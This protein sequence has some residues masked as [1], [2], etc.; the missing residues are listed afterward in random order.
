MLL[1]GGHGPRGLRHGRH[2][3]RARGPGPRGRAGHQRVRPR[4]AGDRDPLCAMRSVPPTTS[5]SSATPCGASPRSSTASSARSRAKPF[6]DG[7]GSGAHI[8]FSL[9]SPDGSRNLMHDPDAGDR[10]LSDLGRSFVAGV[11]QH[12][13][14]LVALTCP[15][16]NSYERL[17]PSA[18]A[19][20]TVSWGLDNREGSVRVASP[21]RGREMESTNVE[22]KACDPS[23]NP[24]LA[25]GG[26]IHAGLDGVRRGLEPPEPARNDPARMTEAERD[27]ERHPAAAGLAA[28]GARGPPGRRGAVRDARRHA[29][30]G[31]RR[32][33]HLRGRRPRD[34]APGRGAAGAPS[35]V[36]TQAVRRIGS[37]L[38]QMR[39]VDLTQPLDAGTVMWPG[40][41]APTRGDH[42]DR[43]ARRVLQPAGDVHGAHR[44]A[45]RRALPHGAR[46]ARLSTQVDPRSSS[47][48]SR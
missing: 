5:S 39:V 16:F 32:G 20:S 1:V 24:Y 2:R 21:F 23:C 45:L 26:L 7:V 11:L 34:D 28:R 36:L 33:P 18:W 13:P 43:R 14:A 37:M 35:S 8:H 4:P 22:L 31:H 15:S 3:R 40:A 6:A 30:A 17:Q 42:P 29:R 10:L 27:R 47:G 9:W 25:L 12:L 19:G 38:G 44:H 48:R 46:A 41:P